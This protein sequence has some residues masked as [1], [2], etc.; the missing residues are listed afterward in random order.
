M[1]CDCEPGK[2][3]PFVARNETFWAVVV[4]WQQT[5]SP[6]GG[7]LVAATPAPHPERGLRVGVVPS[8][9][10]RR[11]CG[12]W[13][14][15]LGSTAATASASTLSTALGKTCDTGPD[16]HTGNSGVKR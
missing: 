1:L 15:G 8:S 11:V 7:S 6:E 9:F 2:I 14:C 10:L 3:V 5:V 12:A 13:G 4:R 16:Q